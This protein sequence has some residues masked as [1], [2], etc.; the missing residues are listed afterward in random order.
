M[1]PSNM[2]RRSPG[3]PVPLKRFLAVTFVVVMVVFFSYSIDNNM[4]EQVND[5]TEA[6]A[7][8]ISEI[9]PEANQAELETMAQLEEIK[10]MRLVKS[11]FKSESPEYEKTVFRARDVNTDYNKIIVLTSIAHGTAY[12][13]GRTFESFMSLLNTI[14][15]DKTTSTL[16]LLIGAKDEYNKI[17]EWMEANEDA[18]FFSKVVI[19][20]SQFIEDLHKIDR[21]SR[22]SLNVQKER[23]RAISRSRN[24]LVTSALQD[25]QYSF[26]MDS[27]MIEVPSDLLTRFIKSGK[28]IAVPRVRQGG[29]ENYDFNS[30]VGER[31]SP[32]AEEDYKLD[33]NDPKYIY[34]PG[35][36]GAKHMHDFLH[37]ESF[38]N[39]G[40][41]EFSVKLDSVGG[42]IVFV[43]SEVFKQGIMFP[44]FYIVGTKW[45]RL[46]GFDGIETEG[47]CYQAKTIGYECWGFPNIVAWHAV[48]LQD[49]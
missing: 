4:V 3:V 6:S 38:N 29:A 36:A 42:A 40:E 46:E 24:F 21:D 1:N 32:N 23:R 14:E 45:G 44:P 31:K 47:L 22:H 34:I 10:K 48:E 37:D 43:K 16:G 27:D 11:I 26:C 28:D 12:G 49:G 9:L 8:F 19:V 18:N 30:W 20:Q 7:E 5:S 25:E 41:L 35:A 13:E 17:V 39:T 33:E 2:L 15:F